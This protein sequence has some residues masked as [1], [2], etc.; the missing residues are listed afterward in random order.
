MKSNK[1]KNPRSSR[2]SAPKNRTRSAKPERTL[3]KR[4]TTKS[5]RRGENRDLRTKFDPSSDAVAQEAVSPGDKIHKALASVG[6]GSR[7]EIEGWIDAGRVLVNGEPAHVGQRVNTQDRIEVDGR[8]IRL[9]PALAGEVLILNKSPGT[10]C[11]RQDPE[12]RPTIFDELPKLHQGRWISVGRLDL[13]TSGLL[14]VTTDGELANKLMHPSTG[15]DRE[16]A[17]RVNGLLDDDV[18]EQ[19]KKGVD[20]DG[21]QLSFSDI[22]YYD[23]SGQNQWYHVVLMEG[24]NRE[25]RRLF[26]AVGCYVSR[27]KRVRYG[28]V[29][30]PSWLRNG[31]WSTLQHQ[32]VRDLYKM[33]GMPYNPPKRA[34]ARQGRVA[35]TTCL[36]P[37]PELT[38][39][40]SAPVQKKPSG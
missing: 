4:Q 30:L 22:Q 15:L 40:K 5:E 25:V 37:Y 27:L 34:Q 28:P 16:Y 13:Q 26:E 24:R 23:G 7:R 14:L 17:V 20:I 6:L 18:L 1:P 32:D 3:N 11:T 33:L 12:D 39:R 35:K 9:V 31:Q 19:L 2:N 10:V 21:E 29:V 36:L 38:Q 8:R